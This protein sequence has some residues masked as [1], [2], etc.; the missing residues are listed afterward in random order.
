MAT[1]APHPGGGDLAPTPKRT[2][3]HALPRLTPTGHTTASTKPR[4]PAQNG[5]ER[6]PTP[7]PLSPATPTAHHPHNPTTPTPTGQKKKNRPE[8]TNQTHSTNTTTAAPR[9]HHDRPPA[10]RHHTTDH[11]QTTIRH[12]TPPRATTPSHCP[13]TSARAQHHTETEDNRPPAATHKPRP[14]PTIYHSPSDNGTNAAWEQTTTGQPRHTPTPN[15]H[16]PAAAPPRHPPRNRGQLMHNPPSIP[17]PQ[18][19]PYTG[20]KHRPL[21]ATGQAKRHSTSRAPRHSGPPRPK[22][23]PQVAGHSRAGTPPPTC[24]ARPTARCPANQAPHHP[25][26]HHCLKRTCAAAHCPQE[27]DYDVLPAIQHLLASLTPR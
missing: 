1:N 3:R 16:N 12:R 24:T 9:A 25:P 27:D 5:E 23:R 22:G 17:T 14:R 19:G 8:P 10:P 18:P 2:T 20:N 11:R 4:P 7:Q 6:R 15:T 26:T 13:P 21:A